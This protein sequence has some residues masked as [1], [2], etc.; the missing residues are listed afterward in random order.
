[1]C[2]ASLMKKDIIL[3]PI[4]AEEMDEDLDLIDEG[5]QQVIE[6]IFLTKTVN[7]KLF[8]G[9]IVIE[10]SFFFIRNNSCYYF[11]DIFHAFGPVK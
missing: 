10:C 5:A 6:Q 1:M 9:T 11:T 4:T 7:I 8:S 3:P 2:A